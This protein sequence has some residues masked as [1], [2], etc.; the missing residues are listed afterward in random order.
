[1]S[2]IDKLRSL[3]ETRV[4]DDTPCIKCHGG[5]TYGDIREVLGVIEG[6]LTRLATAMQKDALLS[7]S[8]YCRKYLVQ[9]CHYCDAIEC[10]DNISMAKQRIAQ[11]ETEVERLWPRMLEEL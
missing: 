6:M 10:G 5:L 4:D 8:E 7:P 2:I 11:L 1:M 9:N 3:A